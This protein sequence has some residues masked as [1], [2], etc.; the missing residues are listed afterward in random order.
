MMRA[1]VPAILILLGA[2]IVAAEAQPAQGRWPMAVGERYCA[3]EPTHP[4][5]GLNW[6]LSCAAACPAGSALVTGSCR[7]TASDNQGIALEGAGPSINGWSCDYVAPHHDVSRSGALSRRVRVKAEAHCRET[8][9][10]PPG[11]WS[12]PAEGVPIV[13]A[14]SGETISEKIRFSVRLCNTEGPAPVN[15]HL[16]L[17]DPNQPGIPERPAAMP[18][19]PGHCLQVD[20]PVAVFVQNGAT[21]QTGLAGTY[22]LYKDGTFKPRPEIASAIDLARNA[23]DEGA[24]ARRAVKATAPELVRARCERLDPAPK[25]IWGRCAIPEISELGNYRI[26]FAPNYAPPAN[27]EPNH[28][29]ALLPMVVNPKLVRLPL[30]ADYSAGTPGARDVHNPIQAN[31]CR[32]YLNVREVNVLMLE[33][34]IF[35]PQNVDSVSFTLQRLG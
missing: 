28:P 24:I 20:Q 4:K 23:R 13:I 16:L 25:G 33:S 35:P 3:G 5:G 12:V 10:A 30:P 27:T 7:V 11:R 31:A 18:V 29:G 2:S 1:S 17:R 34:T 8:A 26:C 22:Q 9:A 15:V 19:P 32:D 6:R 14:R 21:Q